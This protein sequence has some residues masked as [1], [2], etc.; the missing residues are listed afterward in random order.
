MNGFVENFQ[1]REK[2]SVEF[3]EMIS[4]INKNAESIF[5]LIRE[6]DKAKFPEFI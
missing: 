5:F 1:P 4:T 2:G 3:W 6:Y